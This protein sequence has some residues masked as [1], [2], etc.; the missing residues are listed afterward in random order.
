MSQEEQ[1]DLGVL[2]AQYHLALNNDPEDRGNHALQIR[3]QMIDQFGV[4]QAFEAIRLAKD[5]VEMLGME[6]GSA[7]LSPEWSLL[8]WR[9]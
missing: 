6:P 2:A 9:S 7:V 5:V 8:S 4:R 3:D 1:P